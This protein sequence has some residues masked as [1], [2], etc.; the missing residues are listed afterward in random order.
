LKIAILG[1]DIYTNKLK[2]KNFIYKFK[3]RGDDVVIIGT[4][5][6]TR[7]GKL[8]KDISLE[9]NLKYGEFL[10]PHDSYSMYCILPY[11]YYDKIYHDNNV[12]I[13]NNLIAKI[14][15][16]FIF[17]GDTDKSIDSIKTTVIKRDKK[18]INLH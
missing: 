9:F 10:L 7:F 16:I 2:I 12:S 15:D 14:C 5:S 18:I 3:L 17:F 4:G 1:R 8:V 13:R 6:K 11:K